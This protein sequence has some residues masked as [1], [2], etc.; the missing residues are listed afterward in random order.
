M[1]S[2]QPPRQPRTLLGAITQAVQS[3]QAK[4]NFSKLTVKP[5]ARVPEL[6]VQ[7]ADAPKAE[8]YPLLG[9]RYLLGRSSKAC[10]IVVP[11]PVVSQTHLSLTRDRQHRTPFVIQDEGSTNGIYRGKRRIISSALYHGD[12]LTLGPPELAAAVRL[13]YINPP[14][15]YI[16]A[17]RFGL[18]GIS[19]FTALA[20]LWIGYEA[21]K[22]S[23]N[24]LPPVT[25]APVIV[26]AGDGK[27]LL[28]PIR[29]GTYKDLQQLEDYGQYLPNAVIASEDSRYYWHVGV[30][31]IGI[32]RAVVTN[33]R[34]GEI[35]EG[36]STITQQTARS[37]FRSY[38][39][40]SDSAGRKVR[41]A[42]VALKLEA[43]YNKKFILKTYLSRVYLGAGIYGFE[44][45]AQFYF[46]KAVKNLTL[47]E[48]ATLVGILP[49]P[50]S[51]NPV[52]NP[53]AAEEFRNRVLSRMA[54]M[55][56]VTEEEANRAR[57]S[58]IEIAPA[59]RNEL[60]GGNTI[61]P[62]F[63]SYVFDE[64]RARSPQL[65]EEGNLIIETGLDPQMQR[66]ME[67]SFS[68]TLNTQGA[69]SGFSQAAMVTLN[70]STGQI[71]ALVGGRDYK[72]S[73]FNRATQAQ[74][75]PG[76]TFK[77]F[78]YTTAIQQGI[79]PAKAYSCAPLGWEGQ[80]FAGCNAG[81]GSLDLATGLAQSENVVALRVAQE[82]GL[83]RVIQ[84]ARQMGVQSPLKSN[85]GLVLGGSES[86]LL[87][88]TGAFSVLANRGLRNRPHAIS[89][90][91]DG[92]DCSDRNNLQ[93]CRVIYAYDRDPEVNLKVLPP[94]VADTMTTLL[95]GVV[96]RGT[97]V[98]ANVSAGAAGKTGTTNDNV[99]LWF[100]GYVPQQQLATG[101]WLGNDNNS[102]TGGSSGQAAALW[103][104]YMGQVLR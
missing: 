22:V 90:I 61:A 19:G 83:D 92:G 62:Y 37:V 1:T 20:L 33:V 58:L 73:Q 32:L 44:G 97:G 39:G 103:G 95:Q 38:V 5:N 98:N 29:T 79:S 18:Y 71:V 25:Q 47:S 85:P 3:V 70:T 46:G 27:T 35:R 51:F 2:P 17:I 91:L 63:Y 16:R 24:P 57:R 78:A 15:W 26:L 93:S 36:A 53:K 74:R 77:I 82:V 43:T 34:G 72:E 8:I 75:Q 94:E 6:W 66:Q 40:T 45:A 28:Q 67:A 86:T 13:Q 54:A 21:Q 76:S 52:R 80:Y 64:L 14:P 100:I 55:G 12:V 87:E 30:D 9:D 88:M 68:N 101:V 102:P 65:A 42:I 104:D 89:R 48:A 41:E 11:N 31:P 96:Q 49:A 59:A 7:E 10:D 69:A 23:V 50:N 4:I 81:G 84:T 99:D 60:Q 56:M